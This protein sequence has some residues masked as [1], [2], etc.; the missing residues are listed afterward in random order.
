MKG[1][2]RVACR[3][4]G[5][6]LAGLLVLLLVAA[7]VGETSVGDEFDARNACEA[8]ALQ[9]YRQALRA[10]ELANAA[11][12]ESQ[13]QNPNPRLRCYDAAREIY[14]RALAEC[15]ACCGM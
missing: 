3:G 13:A 1:E 15:D 4:R 10:C 5:K 12:G 6:A 8:K 2:I 7:P 9:A 11:A 14:L